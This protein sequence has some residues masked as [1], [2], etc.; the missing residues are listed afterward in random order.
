MFIKD[1]N[2]FKLCAQLCTILNQYAKNTYSAPTT[3]QATGSR[4]KGRDTKGISQLILIIVKS[5]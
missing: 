2:A 3:L 5:E 4:T 1:K